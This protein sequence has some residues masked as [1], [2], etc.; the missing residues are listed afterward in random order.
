MA[1]KLA[2]SDA[3]SL[4]RKSPRDNVVEREKT[5]KKR[6]HKKEIIK[7][8]ENYVFFYLVFNYQFIFITQ[9]FNFLFLYFISDIRLFFYEII[10]CSLHCFLKFGNIAS[11]TTFCEGLFFATALYVYQTK[12]CKF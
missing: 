3:H 6:S 1:F 10:F 9:I 8:R 4:G 11:F 7:K 12:I 2:R 5:Y